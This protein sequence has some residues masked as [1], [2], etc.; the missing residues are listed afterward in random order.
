MSADEG[1]Q[2]IRNRVDAY[3]RKRLGI[4]HIGLFQITDL[5]SAVCFEK[6]C[7]KQSVDADKHPV[8][9]SV[10]G[11][12]NCF[13]VVSVP[14]KCE[15]SR[16]DSQKNY[17]RTKGYDSFIQVSFTVHNFCGNRSEEQLRCTP[18]WYLQYHISP[19]YNIIAK[20]RCN[21]K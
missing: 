10:V 5:E 7:R 1:N 11:Q 21:V 12:N 2:Q 4:Q 6:E 8:S 19:Q 15:N 3:H 14:E 18:F 16:D 9:S 13:A 17:C 20:H